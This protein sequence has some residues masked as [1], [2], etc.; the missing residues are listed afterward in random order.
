MLEA[1]EALRIVKKNESFFTFT[2]QVTAEFE[3]L[4]TGDHF[5]AIG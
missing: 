5:V 3:R 4:R 2:F 1:S